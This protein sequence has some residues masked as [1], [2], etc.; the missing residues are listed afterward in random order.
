VTGAPVDAQPM[1]SH[2]TSSTLLVPPRR[3]GELLVTRRQE[4]GRTSAD[5]EAAA[6]GRFSAGDLRQFES[7]LAAPTDEQLRHL[8]VIY[9]LDLSSITPQRAVLEL[10]LREGIVSIGDEAERFRPTDD[11]REI[12]L[13]YLAIVYRMRAINPGV[14]IPA[15]VDDLATLAQIFSTTTTDIH[16]ILD[17]LMLQERS[18]IRRRHQELRRRL[19][20]PALGVLVALT[21]IGGLVLVR[22]SDATAKAT[23]LPVPSAAIAVQIGDALTITRGAGDGVG[24]AIG[25]AIVIER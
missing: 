15:R 11:D 4:L 1:P 23:A 22:H 3:F 6:L 10:D 21:S 19:V 25:D 9:G 8:A 13:R 5:L 18:E 24:Y 2:P 20:V 14:S 17:S 16:A 12:L 7:G